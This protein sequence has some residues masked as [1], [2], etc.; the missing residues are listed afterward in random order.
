[1]HIHLPSTHLLSYQPAY[2]KDL[3]FMG[4]NIGY[5]GETQG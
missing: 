2:S 3:L 4:D 5:Q 1:M